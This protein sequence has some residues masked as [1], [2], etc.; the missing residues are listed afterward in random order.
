MERWLLPSICYF[1]IIHENQR[2][3]QTFC[4]R[5][6]Q[7]LCLFNDYYSLL[8]NYDCMSNPAWSRELSESND[9][10]LQPWGLC[11]AAYALDLEPACSLCW[12]PMATFSTRIALPVPDG[13]LEYG[14]WVYETVPANKAWWERQIESWR[15]SFHC[16]L[17]KRNLLSLLCAPNPTLLLHVSE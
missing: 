13:R 2:A 4:S 6:Q 9:S 16:Y 11:A 15:K 17:I 10:N 8:C 12:L 1:Y 5:L 7:L 14:E 3:G